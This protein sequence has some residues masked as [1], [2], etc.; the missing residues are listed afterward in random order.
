M[1]RL[2]VTAVERMSILGQDRVVTGQNGKSHLLRE[3][4]SET[5]RENTTTL[6]TGALGYSIF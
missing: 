5:T 4:W 1:T 2:L 6:A 3:M